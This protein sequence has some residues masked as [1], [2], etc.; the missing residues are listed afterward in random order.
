MQLQATEAAGGKRNNFVHFRPTDEVKEQSNRKKNETAADGSLHFRKERKKKMPKKI[1]K[2]K[3][4]ED[5]YSLVRISRSFL[6]AL[7]VRIGLGGVRE[8]RLDAHG[9]Q[10]VR[11]IFA[12][13]LSRHSIDRLHTESARCGLP[14]HSCR[15]FQAKGIASGRGQSGPKSTSA[16]NNESRNVGRPTER[17]RYGQRE[18]ECAR[19][20]ATV[21]EAR[22]EA[23]C[24]PAE[25]AIYV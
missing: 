15:R 24:I 20:H 19:W 6:S 17:A 18:R 2:S 11:F 21:N 10:C 9:S 3:T 13:F 1:H 22:I 4:K 16:S 8:H 23:R 12:S 14:M 25:R 7:C 5:K